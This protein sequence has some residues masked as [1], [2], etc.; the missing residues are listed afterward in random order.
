MV[1]VKLATLG[2][3]NVERWVTSRDATKCMGD[4]VID[5]VRRD[6]SRTLEL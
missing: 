3:G 1:Q 2:Y 6:K 4:M 5:G